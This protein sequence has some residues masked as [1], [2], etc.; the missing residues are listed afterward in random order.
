MAWEVVQAGV[1]VLFACCKLT[2]FNHVRCVAATATKP[3]FAP[4]LIAGTSAKHDTTC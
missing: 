1:V 4:V 2:L 3:M